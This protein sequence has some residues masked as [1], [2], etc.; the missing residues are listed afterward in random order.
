MADR[1][2]YY[3]TPY[4]TAPWIVKAVVLVVAVVFFAILLLPLWG[5][6]VLTKFYLNN[7]DTRLASQVDAAKARLHSSPLFAY[8]SVLAAVKDGE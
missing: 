2:M 4:R 6:P 7:W 5:P 1:F 8:V 3:R